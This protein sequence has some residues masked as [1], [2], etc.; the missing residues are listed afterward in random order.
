LRTAT[1][2]NDPSFRVRITNQ[3]TLSNSLATKPFGTGVGTIGMWG[4]TYNKHI[5]TSQIPPDSY[6]VKIWAMYGIVG[7]IL[8]FG[9]M[10]YILGK[11]AGLIWN[12]RD[13]ALRNQLCALAAGFAGNLVCS[14]GNEVMNT[15]PSSAILYVSWAFIWMSTRWDTPINKL[16]KP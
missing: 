15:M 6:F 8:W 4:V 5:Y 3:H 2:P 14:Y 10:L 11:S 9:I 1:D 12:T 16:S 13:H 7:F